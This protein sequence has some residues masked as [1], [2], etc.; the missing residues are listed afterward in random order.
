[1]PE[2]HQKYFREPERLPSKILLHPF[3]GLKDFLTVILAFVYLRCNKPLLI[4]RESED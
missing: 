2:G 4:K 3:W 1:M